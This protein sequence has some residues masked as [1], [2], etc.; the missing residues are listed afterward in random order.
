MMMTMM[1][2][3]G[4]GSHEA[5][6]APTTTKPRSRIGA[7]CGCQALLLRAPIAFA[8]LMHAPQVAGPRLSP[9]ARHVAAGP[10][11][12]ARI[13]LALV[14]ARGDGL[15]PRSVRLVVRAVALRDTE[16][17]NEIK[18]SSA[19]GSVCFDHTYGSLRN[20]QW[21]GASL[22]SGSG[23]WPRSHEPSIHG[24][25]STDEP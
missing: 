17:R 15:G 24:A 4:I 23:I 5:Q 21:A 18:L 14:L 11:E 1:R 9:C 8:M 3:A 22:W 20:S 16:R 19:M 2:T 25:V 12:L 7:R 6:P 13:P 10:F